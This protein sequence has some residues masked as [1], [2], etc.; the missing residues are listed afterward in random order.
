[1][2]AE[3]GQDQD[4][5]ERPASRRIDAPSRTDGFVGGLAE[6]IGG[7]LGEHAPVARRSV[8]FVSLIVLGL[9]LL[10][11]SL[12][13][14]QKSPCRDGAWTDYKQYTNFCYTDVL[15]LYYAEGLSDGQVPYVDHA[16]EYPVLTGALMG[17]VGL[18][19]HAYGQTHPDFNQ[20]QAFYD[21]TA[22]ILILFALA[23]VAM[24]IALRRDRPWD[25]AMFALSPALLV[26]ATVNWDFLA[27]VLA[28][29]GVYAWSRKWPGYW[30]PALTGVLLG[31]GTA[32]K[33][34]PGFLF[35][36]LLAIALRTWRWAPFFV[37]AG[38]ATVTW[39]AVNV[40][41]MMVNFDNWRR[42]IDLNNERGVDWGV[43]YYIGR[44][45]DGKFWSGGEGDSGLFQWLSRDENRSLLNGISLALF[46]LCCLAL[47]WLSLRAP[48]PPR[49]TQLAFLTVAAFLLFNKVWSQQ[50]TLWLLPL[51]ILARPRWG[52]FLAWQLAEVAYF[53]T[54]YGELLGASGK[55]VMPEGVFIFASIARWVTVAVLCGLVIRDIRYPRLDVVRQSDPLAV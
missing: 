51:A 53:L 23:T 6:L 7:R 29:A 32:A 14:V 52:A 39:L 36:G 18:P 33:L 46:A 35:V 42:F 5:R 55:S 26:T 41:V 21:L 12:H 15:A 40:P 54:F 45:V 16:V 43:L 3:V 10:T 22:L 48:V 17:L 49:L 19:V 31:L 47:I 13:F 24:M 50:F 30:A 2:Q 4:D 25:A 9:T 11:L 20:G 34:W 27:I 28:V 8:K 37:A 1:V 38:T 44:Y